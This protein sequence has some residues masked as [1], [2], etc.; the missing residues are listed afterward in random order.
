MPYEKVCIMVAMVISII[1]SLL[2]SGNFARDAKVAV[3][4]LDNS[5]YTRE[6]I[7]KMN[8]SE[9]IRVTAVINSSVDPRTLC[10]EDDAVAVVYFPRGIEKDRYNGGTNNI[11][12]FYDNT[13]SASTANVKEALNEIV[14]EEN[15]LANGDVGSTND[16]ESYTLSLRRAIL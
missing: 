9:Y 3:I 16:E 6:M 7:N 11:G 4:D 14:G 2:L 10:Y 15:A 8:A 5:A 1:L 13:S 12:V